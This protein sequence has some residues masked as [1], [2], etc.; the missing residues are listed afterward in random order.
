VSDAPSLNLR[1]LAAVNEVDAAVWDACACPAGEPVN[2]FPTHAFLH[3]LEASGSAVRER[4]WQPCHLVL[5][6]DAGEVLG[7]VPNY[8]K[9]HS[10]GEYVFDHAWA[11]AFHRAGGAYYPKL[12]SAIPFT[13]ATGP[14]LLARGD[15]ETR[16]ATR[17]TL[18][19]GLIQACR[20]L[21]LSGTHVLFP[22]EAE[23]DTLGRAGFLRRLDQQFHWY[24]A[25]YAT[26]DDFLG[27]LSSKK[28]KNLKRE[29]RQALEEGITIEWVTGDDLTEAHWDAFHEFYVDTGSRKW[30]TPYLTREFFSRIGEVMPERVLLIL[31]KRAGRWIAGALNFIGDDALYGRHWGCIEDHRCLHFEVCYYQAIDFAIARGLSRVEAG[32]QGGHKVARGYLPVPTYSAHWLAH[33]GLRDAV[34]E[35]LERERAWVREDM[36]M[37]D[38]HVPFRSEIDIDAVRRR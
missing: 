27:E 14:R 10:R 21:D 4:G 24:D 30:G 12:L 33:D 15:P 28:R 38:G 11:D 32:A 2:P 23:W 7:A 5:E 8:V 20:E 29:R 16:A 9:G 36:E 26:F 6:T 31:A 3:A 1:T 19:A 35:Y 34:A 18:A 25:G 22:S 13:P 37:I 17:E